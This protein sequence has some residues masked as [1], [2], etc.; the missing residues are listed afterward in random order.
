MAIHINGDED[1]TRDSVRRAA[2]EAEDAVRAV[3]RGIREARH[4]ERRA[5]P[6]SVLT[7]DMERAAKESNASLV[8]CGGCGGTAFAMWDE[9]EIESRGVRCL[10]C[11][12]LVYL[13]STSVVKP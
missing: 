5:L 6:L 12:G 3:R 7:A 8:T 2:A 9:P 4:A 11:G 1:D 13:A 10:V